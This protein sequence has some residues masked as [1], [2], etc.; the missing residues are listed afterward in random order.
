MQAARF[1]S[2]FC[3]SSRFN[4]LIETASYGALAAALAFPLAT[5]HAQQAAQAPP[6][7]A[8]SDQLETVT[9]SARFQT[10]NLQQTPISIT[11]LSGDDLEKKGFDNITDISK[12]VPNLKFDPNAGAFG[13]SASVFIRGVGQA[14]FDFAF[15]PGV[16]L[17]I[18]DIYY[19]TLYGDQFALSDVASVNVLRGPQGTLFGRNTEGGAIQI[20]TV[21]PKGDNSG[22]VEVGYG[23]YNKEQ[24]KGAFD[25][26]LIPDKLAMRIA[27]GVE[28]QDGY[29]DVIDFACEHPKE[30]AA[31]NKEFT[32]G[33]FAYAPIKATTTAPGCKTG[34]L[35]GGY[36]GDYHGALKFT[37][38]DD[39][40]INLT[41]D[42]IDIKDEQPATTTIYINPT[43]PGSLGFLAAGYGPVFLTHNPYKTY[44]GFTDLINGYNFPNEDD[45]FS[46]GFGS[47]ITY[48]TPIGIQITNIAAYRKYNAT[49]NVW[50][51]GSPIALD[52]N[53]NYDVS[54]HQ[55]SE[56]F[57]IAGKLLDGSLDWTAGA[58]YYTAYSKYGA[59]VDLPPFGL[60]FN[61]NDPIIDHN[62]SGFVHGVYHFDDQFSTEVGVRYSTEDKSYTF[63]RQSA[64]PGAPPGTPAFAGFP[65][66]I[67]PY[68]SASS[69]F[70]P[71]VEFDYKWTPDVMTY[72]SVSTGYKGGGVNPRPSSP[73]QILTFKPEDLTAYEAG[74]KT[75]WFDNKL[76]L[77]GDVFL[78]DYKE[79]QTPFVPPGSAGSII[80]NTGHVIL[81]GVEF[82]GAATPMPGLQID[83]TGGW[84]HAKTVNEGV[85]GQCATGSIVNLALPANEATC[86]VNGGLPGEKLAAIPAWK[87]SSG[88]QYSLDLPNDNGTITPRF[89]WFYTGTEFFANQTPYVQSTTPIGPQTATSKPALVGQTTVPILGKQSG[90]ST[91]NARISYDS[92]DGDWTAAFEVHNLTNQFY[93]VNMFGL[94]SSYGNLDATPSMPRTYYFSIKR[95]FNA[96]PPPSPAMP[97]VAPTPAEPAP[98][99]VVQKPEQQRQF[100]VFF[101][102]DKSDIT[103]AAAKVIQAAADA[104]KA[105]NVVQITV[106]GHTDTVGSAKYN[107]AL[108]ER[109]AAA[110]K[111]GLV[112]D[113]VAG[114]E[115]TTIGVGK[116]GLLVPTADGVREPQNRR[117]EIVLQ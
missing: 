111:A 40:T 107:Q 11:S 112:A 15:D 71:K 39:L 104:V 59:L 73:S 117:A 34:E 2:S 6:S 43:Y 18:D 78:S 65:I 37:P 84:L 81:Y 67:G 8:Q 98:A 60:L 68:T 61:Q 25:V 69:R 62:T 52:T 72:A 54:H 4:R 102:F 49:F 10:E 51:G 5:A 55:F 46:W 83:F 19:G 80:L 22:Y 95:S 30:A 79:L 94:L 87:L 105:G 115:I 3:S 100:Q 57:R 108:S 13:N 103:D 32:G 48:N 64:V 29:V 44:Q 113:G 109:R 50:A 1:G 20:T 45:T 85:A 110:V 89:D 28:N 26:S 56:E 66:N 99:P 74:S 36:T 31:L 70:D 17:Y 63:F 75:Q 82:D 88:V 42:L 53:D 23:S 86:Q 14:D 92:P 12:Q 27:V 90:Y 116:T 16:A 41:A 24:F 97:A 101:D 21:E 9:V 47:K 96:A 77:N 76:R 58:Y 35:G 106:T 114:G 7:A 93:Y 33:I 38:N 91:V